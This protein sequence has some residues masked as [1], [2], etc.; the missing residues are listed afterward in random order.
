MTKTYGSHRALDHVSFGVPDGAVTA[1]VG[2]TGAGRTTTL[3]VIAGLVRPD[4]GRVLIDGHPLAEARRPGA[5]VGLQLTDDWLP[6]EFTLESHLAHVCALQGLP[7]GRVDDLLACV[8]LH[9]ARHR[10]IKDCTPAMR[11]RLG[12]ASAL[13]GDPHHLLLDQPTRGLDAD[14]TAWLHGI[15]RATATR[16]GAVL[17]TADRLGDVAPVAD[18]VVML[19]RGR[20]VCSGPRASFQTADETMSYVESDHLE[21]VVGALQERGFQVVREGQG[22]VVHAEPAAVGRVAFDHAPGLTHLST[23]ARRSG[24]AA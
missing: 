2:S 21:L 22:A 10:R 20:V 4:H 16:G 7:R 13:S 6:E 11:Q 17:I 14:S 9:G 5:L 19:D 23:L 12:I 3:G 18:H 8:G 15:V 24:G 1:L